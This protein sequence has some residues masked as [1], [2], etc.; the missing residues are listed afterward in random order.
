[1]RSRGLLL[2]AALAVPAL[3]GCR[4][5]SRSSGAPAPT[6]TAPA[7]LRGPAL[8]VPHTRGP[9]KPDGELEEDDW[10]EAART[11]PF[12]DEQGA[13]ARP[14]SDARFL[15]DA[16]HLYLV[17]YAA[18]DDIR[19]AIKE[20]DGPVWTDDAFKLEIQPDVA[21]APVYS[22]DVSAAGVVTDARREGRGP[23]SLA[24]ESGLALGVDRDGTL[25]DASDEDEEW[26]IEA[27]LPLQSLGL[28]GAPGTRFTMAISRCD[29]PRAGGGRRCGAFG[30]RRAPRLLELR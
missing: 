8:V 21:G 25:N 24:W 27:A 10:P 22:I 5:A 18:D 17:L 4:G 11:G 7:A 2:A 9:I 3:L 13:P 29:T 26:V 12:L 28:A 16:D 14:Y 23:R 1:V 30:G 15:W 19:A 6:A 20:H